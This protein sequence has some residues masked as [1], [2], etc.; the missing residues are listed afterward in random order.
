M[1]LHQIFSTFHLEFSAI[2]KL[3]S[4]ATNSALRFNTLMQPYILIYPSKTH[5]IDIW[6]TNFTHAATFSIKTHQCGM[7]FSLK[8]PCPTL[9][10]SQLHYLKL[11]KSP[12]EFQPWFSLKIQ[13]I[14]TSISVMIFMKISATIHLNFHNI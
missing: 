11:S 5:S 3:L 9:N 4:T 1:V 10:F 13:Q 8:S 2:K 7:N 14:I 12:L 6:A